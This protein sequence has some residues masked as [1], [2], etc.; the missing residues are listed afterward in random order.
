LEAIAGIAAAFFIGYLPP[1]AFILLTLGALDRRQ[2]AWSLPALAV[3]LALAVWATRLAG[4]SLYERYPHFRPRPKADEGSQDPSFDYGRELDDK[5]IS[6]CVTALDDQIRSVGEI[7]D[8]MAHTTRPM[9]LLVGDRLCNVPVILRPLLSL[10]WLAHFV[11]GAIF[12]LLASRAAFH[13]LNNPAPAFLIVFP[14]VFQIAFLFAVNLYFVMA[15]AVLC[16]RYGLH[17]VIWRWR[18]L[19][20]LLLSLG[21]TLW[22]M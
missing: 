4:A 19:I 8:E 16:G 13:L 6:E 3:S 17:E 2:W 18:F 11:A 15:V 20:D 22:A 7:L 21:M 1:T 10:W 5:S 9:A 14:L 12:G